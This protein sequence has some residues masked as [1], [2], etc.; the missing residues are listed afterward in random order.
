MEQVHVLTAADPTAFFA[1]VHRQFIK[2]MLVTL[3]SLM[4]CLLIDTK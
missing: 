1:Y 2:I 3:S 4:L